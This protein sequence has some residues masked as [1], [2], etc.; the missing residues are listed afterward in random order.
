MVARNEA[1]APAEATPDVYALRGR[2]LY[3]IGFE[4]KRF[5]WF[6]RA[7]ISWEYS[8]RAYFYEALR[9]TGAIGG[10]TDY[11]ACDQ[12]LATGYQ[13]RAGPYVFSMVPG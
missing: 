7:T 4:R 5:V 8:T 9:A 1:Y 2:W 3:R 6:G 10:Q 12:L 13:F 11:D